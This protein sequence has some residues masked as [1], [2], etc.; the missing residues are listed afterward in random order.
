M[1]AKNNNKHSVSATLTNILLIRSG[2]ARKI[3][4]KYLMAMQ[5]SFNRTSGW[6]TLVESKLIKM[7]IDEKY[8]QPHH[9][10]RQPKP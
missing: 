10:H 1:N 6:Y 8:Y 4:H 2:A 3:P 5:F 9:S 7:Q